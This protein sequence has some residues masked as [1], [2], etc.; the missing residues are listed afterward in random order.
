MTVEI[1]E[2]KE[3]TAKKLNYNAAQLR[4][5]LLRTEDGLYTFEYIM[6]KLGTFGN[7]ATTPE[8]VALKNFGMELLQEMGLVTPWNSQDVIKAIAGITPVLYKK[9]EDKEVLNENEE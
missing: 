8:Q 3:T 5:T 2:T 4:N 1:R 7:A 9:I 6:N